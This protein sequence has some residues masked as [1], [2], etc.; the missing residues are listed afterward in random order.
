MNKKVAVT[1]TTFG[2]HSQEPMRLLAKNN[3]EV[4]KNGFGRVLSADEILRL[5]G[6][7]VGIIAGTERYDS[8]TLKKLEGLKVISRVGV[9]LDGIDIDSAK[10]AG[11]EVVNTPDGPVEAVA[12]LTIGLIF[13]LL[14]QI[15]F[16][17]RNIRAGKWKK[18]F[19]A[20]L[21]GKRAGII[22]YGRI[23]RRVGELLTALGFETAYYDPAVK[24]GSGNCGSM[25]LAGLLKWADIITIHVS[26][27]SEVM[28]DRELKSMK[29]GS[30]LINV[31]RGGTVDEDALYGLLKSGHLAGAAL[32][33][34]KK[35]PY[36]G[37]LRELD[38]VVLTPHVG[39]YAVESRVEMETDAV[40]NLIK[41]LNEVNL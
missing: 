20:L 21:Y 4:V 28:S 25:E 12:E 31:S 2:D 40:K 41:I 30:W 3:F 13:A 17:D 8:D 39:S 16:M 33:V 1:T 6:G 15:P 23:G 22:G 5:C 24:G 9:G 19:G 27:K 36:K 18:N 35:E 11:I 29:K 26:G 34:F 7:C 37:A 32:D 14:R 38:N 10:K